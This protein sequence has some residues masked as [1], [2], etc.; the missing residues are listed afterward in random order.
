MVC[1]IFFAPNS[2]LFWKRCAEK[3]KKRD[4]YKAFCFSSKGNNSKKCRICHCWYFKH[5]FKFQKSVCNGCHALLILSLDISDIT[6]ITVKGIDYCCI[7]SDISKSNAIHLFK[8]SV[9]DDLG[10]MSN[11]FQTNQY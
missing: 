11:A 6:I 5:G 8:N 4:N 2:L 10:F 3:K 7:V 9:L 1:K